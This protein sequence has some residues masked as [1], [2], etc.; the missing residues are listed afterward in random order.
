MMLIGRIVLFLVVAILAIVGCGRAEDAQVEAA[1]AWLASRSTDAAG[2]RICRSGDTYAVAEALLIDGKALYLL[3]LPES[4][5]WQATRDLERD[6]SSTMFDGSEKAIAERLYQTV[7]EKEGGDVD[8]QPGATKR[9]RMLGLEEGLPTAEIEIEFSLKNARID[10]V[11]NG[12]FAER[13]VYE[14]PQW[15]RE[16]SRIFY[17]VN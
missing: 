2:V 11:R 10:K 17:R 6:F 8:I 9:F 1:R 16:G 14:H 13:Y 12:V 15:R 7:A 3:L 4:G 5:G